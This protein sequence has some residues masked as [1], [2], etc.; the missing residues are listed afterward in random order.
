MTAPETILTEA[1]ALERLA[2]TV[3]YHTNRARLL[4]AARR[5]REVAKKAEAAL[6]P[7]AVPLRARSVG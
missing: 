6:P 2:E 4:T 7:P 5:L 1:A 3:R